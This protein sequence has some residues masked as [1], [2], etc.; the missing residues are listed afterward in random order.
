MSP[1]QFNQFNRFCFSSAH[2]YPNLCHSSL[3][4]KKYILVAY[5]G[6][7]LNVGWELRAVVLFY[8]QRFFCV[9]ASLPEYALEKF[10]P[11]KMW[12][13]NENMHPIPDQYYKGKRLLI[14][15]LCL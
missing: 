5:S 13:I 10:D 9:K 2:T 14:A 8:V 12:L 4:L 1:L 11:N 15:I 7:L 3:Y 6:Y